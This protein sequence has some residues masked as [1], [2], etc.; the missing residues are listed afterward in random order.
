M[1]VFDAVTGIIRKVGR[2]VKEFF[3]SN[4]KEND[5]DK[6]QLFL[7]IV[8]EENLSETTKREIASMLSEPERRVHDKTYSSIRYFREDK[9]M[10]EIIKNEKEDEKK[11]IMDF[12]EIGVLWSIEIEDKSIVGSHIRRNYLASNSKLTGEMLEMPNDYPVYLSLWFILYVSLDALKIGTSKGE[13]KK[14]FIES[15][16]I[17]TE[18]APF[19]VFHY[20][21]N[22]EMGKFV[23][24]SQFF[25]VQKLL[26]RKGADRGSYENILKEKIK[27]N[28]RKF[29][30]NYGI[31]CRY[32]SSAYADIINITDISVSLDTI[33]TNLISITEK[34]GIN[35]KSTRKTLQPPGNITPNYSL[36]KYIKIMNTRGK[37]NVKI[38][39]NEAGAKGIKEKTVLFDKNNNIKVYENGVETELL[40]EEIQRKMENS[41]LPSLPH[42]YRSS[43]PDL[44]YLI[45]AILISYGFDMFQSWFILNYFNLK[46]NDSAYEF[47]RVLTNE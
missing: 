12:F 10:L 28:F 33:N 2:G 45:L 40:T 32:I 47:L 25:D 20:N 7:M 6:I 15:G 41:T 42:S 11:M 43:L 36:D 26:D 4:D 21:R 29:Q 37:N 27:K 44:S 1:N 39:T 14:P 35:L 22:L 46:K 3:F 19:S 23:L 18:E 34:H 13:T 17:S 38:I 24:A 9:R 31:W 30:P 8:K 16:F 5:I